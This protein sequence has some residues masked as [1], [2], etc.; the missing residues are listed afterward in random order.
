LQSFPAGGGTTA[1]EVQSMGVPVI[2]ANPDFWNASLIGSRSLYASQEL[3]WNS[4]SEIS[5]IIRESLS[6]DVWKE[7]SRVA[8]EKYNSCFHPD[9]GAD[10]FEALEAVFS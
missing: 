6:S 7:L 1:V 9:R 10:F 4:L 8:I 2:Y 5:R 3:E